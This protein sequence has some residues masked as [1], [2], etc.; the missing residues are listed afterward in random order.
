VHLN[1]PRLPPAKDAIAGIRVPGTSLT[2][3]SEAFLKDGK[4]LIV[5]RCDCGAEST[6]L[7]HNLGRCTKSCGKK[8]HLLSPEELAIEVQA[9]E[10]RGKVPPRKITKRLREC[11]PAERASHLAYVEMASNLAELEE[12][13]REIKGS[14]LPMQYIGPTTCASP[15]QLAAHWAWL[16]KQTS[17]YVRPDKIE[18]GKTYGLW[19]ALASDSKPTSRSTILCRCLLCNLTER[20]VLFRILQSPTNGGCRCT[21]PPVTRPSEVKVGDKFGKWTV[22]ELIAGKKLRARCQCECG[23][24]PQIIQVQG[25]LS[26][27]SQSCGCHN[28]EVRR[29]QLPAGFRKGRLVVVKWLGQSMR[30]NGRPGDSIYLCRCDCGNEKEVLSRHL[31]TGPTSRQAGTLSCGCLQAEAMSV[32]GTRAVAGGTI[33]NARWLYVGKQKATLMRSSWELAVAHKLDELGL[34]WVYE[35]ASHK[36]RDGLRYT[37]DFLVPAKKKWIEVKAIVRDRHFFEKLAA[38]RAAVGKVVVLW[39]RDV[40]RLTKMSVR[41]IYKT[42]ASCE[43]R[44]KGL[45]RAIKQLISVNAGNDAILE[46]VKAAGDRHLTELG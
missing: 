31:N 27:Y 9:R 23:S 13:A 7:Y 19:L 21:R 28:L 3:A 40:E 5:V 46:L 35:H 24:E 34:S 30:G 43:I 25:L 8:C 6:V 45:R 37:P 39:E 41:D 11:T 20:Q 33:A 36:L 15:T 12:Q 22:V 38:F 2:T 32:N 4:R 17:E 16:E 1:R 44:D 10:L 29:N 42:Y 14:V 18:A 26:R